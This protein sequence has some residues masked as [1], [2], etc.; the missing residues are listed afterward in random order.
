M[1]NPNLKRVGIPV[2]FTQEQVQ[3]YIKCAADP[4][5][6]I[7]KYVKI[8]NVDEGLVPF[9]MYP[10]QRTM[11]NT[12]HDNRFVICKLPRQSGKSTV[13]VSYML[14]QILFKDRQSIAI[15]A[16]KGQLARDL[17][18]KIKLAYEHLPKWLQQGIKK[19][20]EGG[21]EVENGSKIIAAATSSSAV[22]G[23][24]YNLVFLDEFAF[25]GNNMADDFFSSVYPTISSGTTTKVFIVSTPNG[26]NH[27]YK[28][29]CD[30]DEGRSQYIPIEVQWN[31]IPGR[32]EK[33]RIDQISNTSE[34]QFKQEFECEF[35]GSVNTLI[36]AAK[37]RQMAFVKPIE[38]KNDF[39]IYVQPQKKHTYVI[40]V[41][42][43]RGVGIDN[44]A[45][46]VVDVTEMPYQVVGKY[47]SSVESPLMY[48]SIIYNV[49]K[50]YNDAFVLVES[51]D[52]GE[53]VANILHHDLEYENMLTTVLKGRAGQQL[54]GGF[55]QKV[56]LGVKTTKQVKRI[57]CS[58]IKDL[59]EGDKI[60]IQDFDIISELSSFVQKGNSYEADEGFHDDLVMCLVLFGW[61]ARSDYFK[62]LTDIDIRQKLYD[63]KISG[64]ED[65]MLPFGLYEDGLEDAAE[66]V[67]ASGDVWTV[68]DFNPFGI[69]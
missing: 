32:D 53:Q 8:V 66:M 31:Q 38:T 10:F 7:S 54:G 3:E 60:L 47:Y 44:H 34:E 28:R 20:N 45:F 24:S 16:N 14:H 67:D 61:A 30:A 69:Y 22:R 43:S 37:L 12:F 23:G 68:V 65:D 64:M 52:L 49:A 56:G 35:L 21:V 2:E 19:W 59:I 11:V 41:D 13:V 48:P 17:L 51:N 5:Y 57:G 46:I 25:V 50:E 15:L 40:T 36:N 6:F 33:W 9:D 55:G 63:T 18:A 1:N 4:E 62:E 58:N 29:W 39:H 26:M 42:T 27:F